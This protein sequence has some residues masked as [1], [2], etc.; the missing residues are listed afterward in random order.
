MRSC[1]ITRR[2][3]VRGCVR[4]KPRCS[5]PSRAV[6]AVPCA[7]CHGD[8]RTTIYYAD[9]AGYRNTE[10]AEM[11]DIPVG[12]VASRLRRG[13]IRLRELLIDPTEERYAS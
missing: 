3:R 8:L 13:R 2:T 7:R 5:A 10:I 6:R 9:V 4:R 12:T 1:G 11:M